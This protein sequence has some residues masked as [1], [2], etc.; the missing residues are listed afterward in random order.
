MKIN[1]IK[2]PKIR[3]R[4]P[5]IRIRWRKRTSRWLIGLVV[6]FFVSLFALQLVLMNYT[7]SIL[8][9]VLN[10]QL[11]EV[12][13][14]LYTTSFDNIEI[15]YTKKN[16]I[17]HNLHLLPRQEGA[18][19]GLAA[20]GKKVYEIFIP[21]VNINGIN[22]RKAYLQKFLEINSLELNKAIIKL[23]FNLDEPESELGE[24]VKKDL[25]DLLPASV[26]ELRV[27]TISLK[28]ARLEISALKN[29]QP[30]FI[31]VASL[32]LALENFHINAG[33]ARNP[34]KLFF[35]DHLFL[36]A[37]SL[38]GFLVN[39]TYQ[40]KLESL[41]ISSADSSAFARNISLKPIKE[42]DEML[43]EQDLEKVYEVNFPQLYLYGLSFNEL[44]HHQDLIAS[45]ITILN[46]GLEL[47]NLKPLSPGKKESFRLDDLYPVIDKVLNSIQVKNLYLKNG[48]IGIRELKQDMQQKLSAGIQSAYI[49][50]FVL[51]SLSSQREDQ[52]LYSDQIHLQLNEY[53]LRLSDDLHLLQAEELYFSSDSAEIWAKGFRVA[54]EI[55]NSKLA[56][57]SL[58][59]KAGAPLIHLHGV[60]MLQA[61]N[62]NVLMIDSLQLKE[63]NLHLTG[64]P[65]NGAAATD[66]QDPFKEEDLYALIEDYLYTLSI[67]KI[68][69]Q[70]GSLSIKKKERA[71]EDAFITNIRRA[72]LWNFRLDST[73]AYQ[74]SKLFYADDFELEIANYEHE[75]PDGLH[76]ITADEIGIS[77]LSERIYI[78]DLRISEEKSLYPYANLRNST[79]K[80][81][82]NLQ[83]PFME[84]EGVDILK[85]YL[86][87]K[88][89]VRQVTI[90][91]PSIQLGTLIGG[92]KDRSNLIKSSALYDLIQEYLELIQVQ[93]LYLQEGKLD[94]AFYA[95]E[96][97]L[98][99]SGR[100]TNIRIDNFRFDSLTSTN[101]KRLFFADNV[102]VEVEN[103]ES[104][105]PDGIH[106]IQAG[107]LKASTEERQITA[108]EV[109]VRTSQENY[110]DDELLGTYQQRS[111]I[112][113]H[114]P[115]ILL[116]GLDFDQAYYQE[117]LQADT[118]LAQ[119]PDVIFTYLPKQSVSNKP[120][121]QK[122]KQTDFYNAIAPYLQQFGIK[123]L[124]MEEGRFSAFR[125][126]NGQK[127][128][129]TL[130]E[131]I[132]FQMDDFWV[133]S[134]AVFDSKRFLY[135]EDIRLNIRK[136][137]QDLLDNI[138]TLTAENLRLSTEKQN[139]R[140]GNI[141]L[142][143]KFPDLF[144][145]G[146][147]KGE[148]IP[149]RYLIGLPALQINGISFDEAYK[150]GE[151]EIKE[152]LLENPD[153]R[154]DDYA[155]KPDSRHEKKQWTKYDLH[156]LIKGNLQSLKVQ[157]T[158]ITHGKAV[159]TQHQQQEDFRLKAANFNAHIKNFKVS[160]ENKG[161]N[162][163]FYAEDIQLSLK[164]YEIKLPDS[165]HILRVEELQ[166]STLEQ[167]L[168]LEGIQL[169]PRPFPD[170]KTRLKEIEKDQ[171]FNI[172]I[173]RVEIFGI[174]PEDFTKD[175]LLFSNI[176]L[177]NPSVE[178]TRFS[179]LKK[180]EKK[181]A[182]NNWQKQIL[183]SFKLI[184]SQ[185]IN[186][187]DGKLVFTSIDKQDSSSFRLGNI[188]G[189]AV[190]FKL[191]SLTGIQGERIFFSESL[192]V[193]AQD[194]QSTFDDGLYELK[195]KQV[196]FDTQKKSITLDSLSAMP[197][198]ERDVFAR[199]KGYE[200]DQFTFRNGRLVVQNFDFHSFF[201]KGHF[202][203]DSLLL[204][205]FN[206]YVY[207][208]KRQPY[209]ENHFPKMPQEIL[210]Q[211]DMPLFIKGF[212]IQ[213]G[214]VGYSEQAKEAPSPGFIDLTDVEVIS[215][216]ISNFPELLAKGL[217]TNL[218]L[219]CY[220]MGTGHLQAMFDIPIEDSL[221]SHTVYGT[222][223]GMYLPDF[224]PILEKTVFI[225]IRSGYADQIQF[226]IKA[227]RNKAVGTMEFKYQ[228][229][230]VAL[231]N[232][233]TGNTGGVFKEIGSLFAN[234]FVVS[235]NNTEK[236]HKPIRKGEMVYVRDER[237]SVVNYWVKTLV[238]GFKSSVGL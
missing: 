196:A 72:G 120:Q 65:N 141:W 68:N 197:L 24:M 129:N 230:K 131:G 40:L 7:K 212:V 137:K 36:E 143:P 195:I 115:K 214:Y 42:V 12:T 183:S 18:Q 91:N 152:L 153:I 3:I 84:L 50:N 53:S 47:T 175:S 123:R 93:H 111:Y 205:D 104:Q 172:R 145:N 22:L 138:H 182:D 48:A 46:P 132:S 160:E 20:N 121:N 6:L 198:V 88:L 60:D 166:F 101:P 192:Q 29:K 223:E 80:T 135:A 19:N 211:L 149:K 57:S 17:I 210:R 206:L 144:S 58:T 28:D 5:R 11:A 34:D 202:L 194:Y 232:K 170:L 89:E 23:N 14:G 78:S 167:K 109:W 62:Y 188:S 97:P 233:K 147:S 59:Y 106:I 103:Y 177:R 209:P 161:E 99:V 217:T 10:M 114:L 169:S 15:S 134:S 227:N 163:P 181:Y 35:T 154:I 77:T 155:L 32:Q 44:Y 213:N 236:E 9:N 174:Q 56:G 73:S 8:Q 136:Y 39:E 158:R 234:T 130:L 164:E 95:E 165:L 117:R 142:K 128:E 55:G 45:E 187:L 76:R 225:K 81:L 110:T 49:H 219:S 116:T 125:Q 87:K 82:M 204:K 105:L 191:D 1:K 226:F 37:D 179:D 180:P 83:I 4:R 70:K 38:N 100:Q 150:N 231:V 43:L 199:K 190:E 156:E 74:M 79:A 162:D 98:T 96:S 66:V 173:P 222:L 171:V 33:N 69:L 119:A 176:L 26:E 71:A 220:L 157:N 139:L 228:G 102:E 126:E 41:K 90:P 30:N 85:A 238:N 215:D 185:E 16:L 64:Q 2:R 124:I 13:G 127:E 200:T 27:G 224:N 193:Q 201:S 235:A 216:T 122:L 118:V 189:K 108:D 208:D 31:Q 237:K 218:R 146:E 54:P 221:N 61:Y 52:L 203:A 107:K 67:G 151:L 148:N 133:D 229:L 21:K 184:H 51:D 140:A 178:L 168:A 112:N 207:R 186:L 159:Y 25:Y 94:L 86:H 92:S 63:P 113:L 75:L